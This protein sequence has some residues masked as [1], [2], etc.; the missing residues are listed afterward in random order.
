M[1]IFAVLCTLAVLTGCIMVPIP[2]TVSMGQTSP[3]EQPLPSTTPAIR[4]F[5]QQFAALRAENGLPVLRSNAGLDAVALAHSQEMVAYGF[6]SHVDR[7]G[8]RAQAR[9][10]NAGVTKCGIGENVAKGQ[11]SVAE[12]LSGWMTSSGHRAN[13]LNRNYSSYGIGRVGNTWTLVFALPC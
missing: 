8:Q 13:M 7:R 10:R 6:V 11:N 5:D 3:T 1:K 12:V 4:A 9:V 2:V